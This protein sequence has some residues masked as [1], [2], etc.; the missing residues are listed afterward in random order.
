LTAVMNL[1]FLAQ[2]NFGGGNAPS[3]PGGSSAGAGSEAVAGGAGA[4]AQGAAGGGYEQLFFIGVMIVVFYFLL[5]RP[6]KKR[7][8]KHK[9]MVTQ[10]SAGDQVITNSGIFGKISAMDDTSITLEVAKGTRI[11]VLKSFV[12]GIANPTTEEDLAQQTQ[13]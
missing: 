9:E 1:I 6:Q 12:G 8:N 4:A 7:A 13:N 2:A 3:A 5:I 10:L 11:R